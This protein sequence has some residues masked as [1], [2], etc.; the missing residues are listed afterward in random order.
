MNFSDFFL[1]LKKNLN[2]LLIGSL[3]FSLISIGVFSIFP[4]S[5]ITEGTFILKPNFEEYQNDK[6][7]EK[8]SLYNYD[9]YY[10]DQ[11]S[12]SYT[13][14]II[15]LIETPEF[16]K[17]ILSNEGNLESLL[18]I[19]LQTNFKEIAPR[20]LVLSVKSSSFE[21][22][23]EL[24]NMY[25]KEILF[26]SEKYNSE[27]VFKLERLDSFTNTYENSLS[28]IIKILVSLVIGVFLSTSF[29][30]LKFNYLNKGGK[31]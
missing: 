8:N 12:Q 24:F 11:I 10:L 18:K 25:E 23:K 2:T 7:T 20:V 26:Y 6:K 16:K 27:K 3:L 19:N 29:V 14:T 28:V 15:G 9:G 4:K 22:S 31:V 21:N 5:F 30:Y 13:K 1:L 17:K